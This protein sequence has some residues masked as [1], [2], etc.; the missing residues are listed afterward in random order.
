MIQYCYLCKKEV[1]WPED[2]PR[3]DPYEMNM[4]KNW[5]RIVICDPCYRVQQEKLFL[6]IEIKIRRTEEIREDLKIIFNNYIYEMQEAFKEKNLEKY[7]FCEERLKHIQNHIDL[8]LE[9]YVPPPINA[10]RRI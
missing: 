10:E 8:F 5:K 4:N 1:K 7:R 2:Q 9:G 3:C 6:I